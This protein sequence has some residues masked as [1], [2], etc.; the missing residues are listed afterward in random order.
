MAAGAKKGT[1]RGRKGPV[2]RKRPAA[3][4]GSRFPGL[5][6][7]LGLLMAL[8]LVLAVIYLIPMPV[9]AP[10]GQQR[11]IFEDFTPAPK[12]P[13]PAEK[14]RPQKPPPSVARPKIAI[15][16]D[17]MGHDPAIDRAFFSLDPAMAFAFLPYAPYTAGLASEARRKGHDVLI[18][19]P[20]EPDNPSIDP[21][22][23]VLTVSMDLDTMIDIVNKA[24]ERVP[25]ACGINNH[26][27]SKFTASRQAMERFLAIVKHKGLFFVDS[28]TT[29]ETVAYRTARAMGVPCAERAVFL[30]PKVDRKTVEHELD[31]LVKVA[32]KRGSAVA[33]GHPH[34]VT[35]QVLRKRLPLVKKRVKLVPLHVLIKSGEDN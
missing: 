32:S 33:I 14:T 6:I 34:R 9:R 7:Y 13:P 10:S 26:M 29:A 24:I 20:M 11:P 12:A 2:G 31:R 30:D 19:I 15:I 28:R 22:P 35:Y 3:G 4:G 16:I 27:G 5:I 18:H 1:K 23:G 8:G 17:D 25:G 21:G